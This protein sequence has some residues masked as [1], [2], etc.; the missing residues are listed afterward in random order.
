M[1]GNHVVPIQH[2]VGV[3][4]AKV[5]KDH[6]NVRV[7]VA[8]VTRQLVLEDMTVCRLQVAQLV[9]RVDRAQVEASAPPY[10][11]EKTA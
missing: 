11:V 2:L 5:A 4:V 1:R 8:T 6:V 10:P 7:A 3:E 9:R